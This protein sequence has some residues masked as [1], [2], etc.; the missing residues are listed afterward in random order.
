MGSGLLILGL[1]LQVYE[2]GQYLLREGETLT[3]DAKFFLVDSGT[4]HCYKTTNGVRKQVKTIRAGTVAVGRSHILSSGALPTC[5]GG[6]RRCP[7]QGV[8]SRLLCED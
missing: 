8:M 6:G 2:D 3:S 5:L 1:P 4:I 7:P